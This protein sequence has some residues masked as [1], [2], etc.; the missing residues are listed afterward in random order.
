MAY[1][2]VRNKYLPHYHSMGVY[3]ETLDEKE[4]HLGP[5]RTEEKMTRRELQ[6]ASGRPYICYNLKSM[7]LTPHE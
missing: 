5:D 2:Q 6:F 3:Q 4:V 7:S 1:L